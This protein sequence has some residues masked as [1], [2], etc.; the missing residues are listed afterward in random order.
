MFNKSFLI[1]IISLFSCNGHA[2]YIIFKK[3]HNSNKF[4]HS[5][6]EEL[7]EIEHEK[8]YREVLANYQWP[9]CIASD[10]ADEIASYFSAH[11]D[12]TEENLIRDQIK[13]IDSRFDIVFIPRTFYEIK[14]IEFKN[15]F[16][17]TLQ[18]C[19]DEFDYALLDYRILEI[20]RNVGYNS[21]DINCLLK[22]NTINEIYSIFKGLNNSSVAVKMHFFI[23]NEFIK[24]GIPEA[25]RKLEESKEKINDLLNFLESQTDG[26]LNNVF[27]ESVN[28]INYCIYPLKRKIGLG[29]I[30]KIYSL[31][32]RAHW[33]NKVLLYRSLLRENPELQLLGESI[34][35]LE[36]TVVWGMG[37]PIY[38]NILNGMNK[39]VLN[40][41]ICDFIAETYDE[42]QADHEEN[43]KSEAFDW[44][45]TSRSISYGNSFFSGFFKDSGA[46][47]F[48]LFC[49]SK[50]TIGYVLYIDRH[51]YFSQELQNLFR[52]SP[53]A[54]DISLFCGYGEF[55][56]SRTKTCKLKY[57]CDV[58]GCD[59]LCQADDSVGYLFESVNPL[60]MSHKLAKYIAN[61]AEIICLSE[62]CELAKEKI[63]ADIYINDQKKLSQ[64]LEKMKLLAQDRPA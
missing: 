64:F 50:E 48:T 2:E 29:E 21:K 7:T 28:C 10:Y 31:E 6:L 32:F 19:Q 33:S 53:L 13:K 14:S 42:E 37:S 16:L 57:N 30:R 40:H 9:M 22:R 58:I 51:A 1:V 11:A 39:T 24:Q 15:L 56:H 18:K 36:Y 59:K 44:K 49:S 61:H 4:F 47:T 54:T 41:T 35:P 60:E 26:S 17:E 3:S 46:C 12:F 23:N 45:R 27:M 55:F 5:K 34:K 52:I 38:Q 43:S 63:K 25:I 20:I 62:S 8:I